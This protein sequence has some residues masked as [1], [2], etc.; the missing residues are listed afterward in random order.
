MMCDLRVIIV[1]N[2]A[3]VFNVCSVLQLFVK[4]NITKTFIIIFSL[5]LVMLV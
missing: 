3:R 1:F 5:I 4:S 2:D